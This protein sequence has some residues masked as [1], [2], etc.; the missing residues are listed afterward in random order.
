MVVGTGIDLVTVAE[1]SSLLDETFLNFVFSQEEREWAA[2]HPAPELSL[3]GIFAAKEAV[4]KALG[5]LY[6]L[7]DA[8]LRDV[9]IAHKATGAPYVR[10]TKKLEAVMQSVGVG[11]ILIS[12]TNED[13]FVAAM[14]VAQTE[15]F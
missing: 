5:G 14:A 7:R 12:I 15:A 1:F 8:D 9:E 3:A 10:P 13:A 6:E 11:S 2:G 4:A